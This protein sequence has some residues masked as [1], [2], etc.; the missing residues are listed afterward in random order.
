MTV[1]RSLAEPAPEWAAWWEA[2][3]ERRLLL[4]RCRDCGRLQH[5]PRSLCLG[6]GS[7]DLDWTEA[8]GWGTVYSHTTVHRAPWAVPAAPYVVALVRLTE[9]PVVLT[10][11]VGCAPADV[12]CELPVVLDWEEVEDGRNLPLFRPA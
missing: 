4:Q 5:Y 11:I 9:G 12:R 7:A 2:T 1:R 8:A 6:C 3:R 10:N